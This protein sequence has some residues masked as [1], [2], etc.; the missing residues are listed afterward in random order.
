MYINFVNEEKKNFYISYWLLLI[1]FLVGLII[2][3]GGLT[4]LTDSGLS[5]TQ[6]NL[7]SGIVPPLNFEDWENLFNLYKHI[8]EYKLLNSSMTVDEFKYIFWWEYIHRMLGRLIGL[9]YIIP[10][11]YFT[12]KR[13]LTKKKII[14]LYFIFFLICLQGL[15]GWYMVKS[16]LTE[17]TDVS[18]YRLSIHLLLA[19]IIFILLFWNYLNLNFTSEI[20]RSKKIPYNIPFLFLLLI[21]I[22]VLTGALVSGLDAGQIYQSWPL[23]NGNFF[24][25]D[26]TFRE[27]ISK[28]TLN[29][30]SQVQFLHRNIAYIIFFLFLCILITIFKNSEY[31]YLR[32]TSLIVLLFLLLQIFLGVLTILSGAHIVIASM[33][34]I[35]S[36][37]LITSSLI[38]VFKN[39]KT[40]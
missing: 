15:I 23:M 9:L 7:L 12:F 32:K 11:L 38:L 33:H 1:T 6:W 4:R 34:Q 26:S 13:S 8:P 25:D 3:V 20:K 19:F 30:P 31:T 17:R 16:G 28:E 29:T 24:P 5:I 35:G 10:L 21:L 27:L 22:Q 14:S 18:H 40:N 39:S 37:L 2:V 36:I